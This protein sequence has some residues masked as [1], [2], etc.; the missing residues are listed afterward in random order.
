MVNVAE[1]VG[2]ALAGLG[3][4]HVFGV[5]GSGNFVVTNAL[6]EHGAA[7]LAARHEGGAISMA[8]GYARVSGRVGVCSVHQGPGLTN[9]MTGLTEAAK[10][11]TPLVV[12]AA[13]TAASAIRSNFRIEQDNLVRSVGAVPERLHG[14]ASA[15][16]DAARAWCR[17]EIERRPVVLML[18]LDVQAAASLHDGR[19]LPAPPILHPVRPSQA[20]VVAAADALE[21]ARRPLIIAG[22]GAVLANAREPVERLG[23]MLGALLATS[24]N[25]NGLFAGNMWSLG[26]SGGFASPAA[27]EL[28]AQA[29]VVLSVGAGL[30]MWT[31]RHGRLVSPSATII[32]IDHEADAIGAHHRVDVAVV[33]D[34]GEAV[35]ALVQELEGRLSPQ[36]SPR[37]R[38][39]GG[40]G[41]EG[42]P[43]WRMLE[44]AER[45]RA[46]TWKATPY[47]D[48]STDTQ[49][50]PRTLSAA[51]DDLLPDDRTLA[52]DSGHFMGYPPMYLRVPDAQ[53]FV[54]TQ[55][56]QAIGLG[57]GSAIGAAVARP[58]RLTVAALGDGG[59]MM[60]LP[61]L[62]TVARL[63]LRMLI[64]VYNDAAYGAEVHH[65]GPMGHPVDLVQFPDVD[66]AA[67]ARAAGLEGATIR[68]RQDLE[69]VSSWLACEGKPGLLLDAKV[70]PT[71]VA[72][73][74][75]EAFRG[76]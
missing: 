76:H 32:Q 9:A 3:A 47:E 72:E 54:F 39:S 56:F 12:L 67:L 69:V 50:D 24:A 70:V 73:W 52:V 44:V 10:S 18:P 17:A 74:L 53:G 42:L 22:R 11:R 68:R 14:P 37:G 30:N 51:L 1:A 66:F 16:A 31:T 28:I 41:N 23:D 25:G 59:A 43:G 75:E 8:D 58:D 21:R 46:G 35:V 48:A 36:P 60:A 61:E 13:D 19:D 40:A 26:I 55:A 62:E 49:I 64:V 33:G 5:L 4:Q 63:G 71:V 27:L 7:F 2:R 20:A 57:L 34:A 38:G 45:I 65:F 6:V 15:V 29:E